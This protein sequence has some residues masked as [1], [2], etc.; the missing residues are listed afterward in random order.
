M[1]GHAKQLPLSK[2]EPLNQDEDIFSPKKE[3]APVEARNEHNEELHASKPIHSDLETN[4][5]LL[6]DHAKFLDMVTLLGRFQSNQV[7]FWRLVF[8]SHGV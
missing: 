8:Y 2:S 5:Q 4:R 7:N 6:E 3:I 1:T